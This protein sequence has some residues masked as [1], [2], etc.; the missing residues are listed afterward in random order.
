MAKQFLTNI[1]LHKNEIMNVAAQ[2][3]ATAPSNPVSGQFYFNTQDNEFKVWNGTAWVPLKATIAI[4]DVTNLQS[5]LTQLTNDITTKTQ[6][7]NQKL[8]TEVGK[9]QQEITTKTNAIKDGVTI[10]TVQGLA[11]KIQEIE[12]A[13]TTNDTTIKQ[14]L[15][16]KVAELK[17][18]ATDKAN[19]VKSDLINSA[20]S[21][22]DT[23]K[24][25][26]TIIK[27]NANDLRTLQGVATKH[28]QEIGDD[29]STEYTVQHN[30]HTRDVMVN[31]VT[32]S[33]PYE[34]VYADVEIVDDN[35][36]KVRTAKPIPSS[37]KI[38]V[39]VFG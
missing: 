28:S 14:Q 4:S 7:T 24:E 18:E 2:K 12:Q 23:F 13:I 34:V 30:L 22:Y 5:Q 37:A 17:Q 35:N 29:S 21:D 33:A 3:L 31:L 11:Q 38:K 39:I 15:T 25:I 27:Q 8:T 20:S 6:A 16:A 9:L 32:V 19:A 1:D 10:A 26:E 36:V